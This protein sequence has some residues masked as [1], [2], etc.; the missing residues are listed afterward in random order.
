MFS[1]FPHAIPCARDGGTCFPTLLPTHLSCC[2]VWFRMNNTYPP[3]LPPFPAALCWC[4][5][6]CIH[7]IP[8]AGTFAPQFPFPLPAHCDSRHSQATWQAHPPPPLLPFSSCGVACTPPPTPHHLPGWVP[9][10]WVNCWWAV[11]WRRTISWARTCVYA[12]P[13]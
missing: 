13:R 8:Y 10:G 3:F 1:H 11:R 2:L 6:L 4:R 7:P 9:V 12:T 5:Y